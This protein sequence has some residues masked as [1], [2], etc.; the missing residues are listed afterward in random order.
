MHSKEDSQHVVILRRGQ[1]YWFDV[2]DHSNRPLLTEREI[3]RN[4]QAIVADADTTPVTE[5]ARFCHWCT[6]NRE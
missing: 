5:V 6:V 4:L 1:F 3:L 2:L